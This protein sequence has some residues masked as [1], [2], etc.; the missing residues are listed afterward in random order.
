MTVILQ[1]F[2]CLIIFRQAIVMIFCA[3]ASDK[4]FNRYKNMIHQNKWR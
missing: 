2:I 4:T 1:Y 3:V